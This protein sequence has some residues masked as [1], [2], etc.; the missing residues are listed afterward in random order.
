MAGTRSRATAA[1]QL[2]YVPVL[3]IDMAN[4]SLRCLW[5]FHCPSPNR[6]SRLELPELGVGRSACRRSRYRA[7]PRG[8]AL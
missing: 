5:C 4:T 8:S 2:D 6:A 1:E 7:K 3:S